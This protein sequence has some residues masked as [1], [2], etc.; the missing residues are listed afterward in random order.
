MLKV[1]S[2]AILLAQLFPTAP[3]GVNRLDANAR[4]GGNRKAI[5]VAIGRALFKTR[6]PAQVLNVYAD[7]V[8]GHVIAGLRISGE[9]FHGALTRNRFVEEVASLAQ[10]TFAASPVDEVDVWASIPLRLGKDVVVAGDLAKPSSRAVFTVSIRRGERADALIRRMRAS[11][12]VFWDQEWA[13]ST[14][15]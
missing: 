13:R 3:P 5:A 1:I 11:D 8:A 9:H 4:A 6:W 10:A 7:G 2:A 12:G 15:K 14:L